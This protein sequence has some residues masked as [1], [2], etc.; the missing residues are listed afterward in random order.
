MQIT[1]LQA[2]YDPKPSFIVQFCQGSR[3][4]NETV[5][6]F[7]A[8][9]WEIA[10]HCEY[11]DNLQEMIC[12][13]LVCGINHDGIQE[14]ILTEK[15]LRTLCKGFRDC[16]GCG[17]SRKGTKELKAAST[18]S[19]DVHYTSQQPIPSTS[20]SNPEKQQRMTTPCCLGRHSPAT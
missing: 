13:R 15:D 10:E 18:V 7:V 5:A 4:P 19:H 16:P 11:K 8:A 2:H 9:L 6:Q 14:R 17:V 12:D 3:G 1:L 20:M